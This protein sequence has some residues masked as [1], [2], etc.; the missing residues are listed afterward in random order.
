MKE[1]TAIFQSPSCDFFFFIFL[2]MFSP[3]KQNNYQNVIFQKKKAHSFLPS[4]NGLGLLF[5]LSLSLSLFLNTLLCLVGCAVEVMGPKLHWRFN[6][7]RGLY[8]SFS[9]LSLCLPPFSHCLAFGFFFF[10]SLFEKIRS[11]GFIFSVWRLWELTS[12]GFGTCFSEFWTWVLE[13]MW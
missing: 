13:I 7:E 12:R 11:W 4:F 9:A 2:F 6:G 8:P 1:T 10:S 3:E 5:S